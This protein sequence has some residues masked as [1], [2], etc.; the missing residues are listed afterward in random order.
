MGLIQSQSPNHRVSNFHGISAR[1]SKRKGYR[2]NPLIIGSQ[3]S[4]QMIEA[5]AD[6]S[7]GESLNPLIIGSQI[8]TRDVPG[9]VVAHH[10]RLNPLIIGSQI[11]T[12]SAR[13]SC[14]VSF[15]SLNPLIIG[16]QISTDPPAGAPW[17][18]RGLNPLIIG[19]QIST[20]IVMPVIS[21]G[22]DKSQS[23]NHRVSNFHL[24]SRG[25]I[26][27]KGGARLNP[28]IIGSQISTA[29]PFQS[30]LSR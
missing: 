3:I 8:S 28:L 19:S 20:A 26:K 23:P 13:D 5:V 15:L 9:L 12:Q 21:P 25:E 10:H 14:G 17:P 18:P 7:T 30:I 1:I 27:K 29:S 2:L 24:R 16:S 6:A 11:S 4:T 22:L